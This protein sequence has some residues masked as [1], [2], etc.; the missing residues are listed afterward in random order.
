MK[1]VTV[2]LEVIREQRDLRDLP[3]QL[4]PPALQGP[5]VTESMSDGI[6]F[7]DRMKRAQAP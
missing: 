2:G 7:K 5:L 3:V 4:D 1:K 6:D